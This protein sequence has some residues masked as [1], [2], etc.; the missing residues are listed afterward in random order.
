MNSNNQNNILGKNDG[1]ND[2]KKDDDD[3]DDDDNEDENGEIPINN[4]SELGIPELYELYNDI[5]NEERGYYTDMSKEM[6]IVYKSD[7]ELFYKTLHGK[8]IPL[9]EEGNKTITK[10]EQIPLVDFHNNEKCKNNDTLTEKYEGTLKDK[11]F[12]EYAFHVKDM[13]NRM[14]SYQDKLLEILDKL[15]S[16][17]KHKN[18]NEDNKAEGKKEEDKKAEDTISGEKDNTN[19][20]QAEQIQAEQIQA[21]QI[22]AQ[23]QQIQQ[24]QMPEKIPEQIQAQQQ[25][26]MP[27]QIQAPA[28][29]Q[30]IQTQQIQAQQ[31][32]Q[33]PQQQLQMPQQIQAQQIQTQQIQMPPQIQ[34]QQIQAQQIQAPAQAQQ[35]QQI[36]MPPPDIKIG[37]KI[38]NKKEVDDVTIKLNPELDDALLKSLI[39]TTREIIVKMYITCETDFLKGITLFEGIVASQLANTTTSKLQMLSKLIV[40]KLDENYN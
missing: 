2:G 13:T 28:Q 25:I 4:R 31:Q 33:M 5:Y 30:Q 16:F 40:K 27:P 18:S 22:Q 1:K 37:G 10:F 7:L 23:A 26:Q 8:D 34:A 21:E 6:K 11:L 14:N 20:N 29:A 12:R 17:K 9:D 36:Q 15:F 19:L 3:D 38:N 32:I 24:I 35:Q 39:K